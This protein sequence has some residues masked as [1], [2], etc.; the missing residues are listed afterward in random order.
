MR[1]TSLPSPA[2][3]SYSSGGLGVRRPSCPGASAMIGAPEHVRWPTRGS[4][5]SNADVISSPR[6][7]WPRTTRQPPAKNWPS[8]PVWR[9]DGTTAWTQPICIGRQHTRPH[10]RPGRAGHRD[11]IGRPHRRARPGSCRTGPTTDRRAAALQPTTKPRVE[12]GRP[13]TRLLPAWALTSLSAQRFRTRPALFDL[14]IIDEASQCSIPSVVPLLFRARRALVIGDAMQLPHIT[15]IN[16]DVDARLR[17]R[18]KVFGIGSASIT[19]PPSSTRRS[20]PRR[21]LPAGRCSSTSIIAAIQP[22]P[23][24]RTG[25]L[26]RCTHRTHQRERSWPGGDRRPTTGMATCGRCGQTRPQR[27]RVAQR[28]RG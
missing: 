16:R 20:L 1:S 12:R 25:L 14:V 3:R 8:W 26:S 27:A 4:S 24:C 11:S 19:S 28:L 7:D 9:D 2:R 10:A 17:A 13:G 22:S 21:K 5:E 6:L 23:R 15:S 18:W